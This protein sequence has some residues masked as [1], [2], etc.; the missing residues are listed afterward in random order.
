MSYW[1]YSQTNSGG[2]FTQPAI[3]VW[4]EADTDTQANQIAEKNGIY[5]DPLFQIDCECCGN[6]W[7]DAEGPY[8]KP[9]GPEEFEL[10]WAKRDGVP[11]QIVIKGEQK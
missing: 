7:N 3:I 10:I 8:E 4:V 1:K 11:A 6:R 9:F 5:F 2:G